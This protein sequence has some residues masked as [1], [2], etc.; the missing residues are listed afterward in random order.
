MPADDAGN[1]ASNVRSAGIALALVGA[2]SAG[3][4]SSVDRRASGAALA[5]QVGIL[6]GL[7]VSLGW[8][9]PAE[10]RRIQRRTSDSLLAATGGAAVI[11][12][13]LAAGDVAAAL[14]AA[15]ED[16]A[17]A[18]TVALSVRLGGR[19]EPNVSAIP[20]FLV[21]AVSIVD[22]RVHVEVR[23]AATQEIIG[24]V[25]TV[26]SGRP[27]EPEVG[28][29]G[30]RRAAL[31]AIDDALRKTV[32]AFAPRLASSHRAF[33]VA[34]DAAGPQ[35]S[36][37]VRL[38]RL[39]ELYPE[40]SVDDMEAL[41]LSADSLL[42]LDPGPLLALGVMRGDLLRLPRAATKSARA[43]LARALSR[44][45]PLSLEVDRHGEH[46]LLAALAGPAGRDRN[47]R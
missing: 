31:A 36:F 26:S 22:Y 38:S 23:S 9:G 37:T 16:P 41:A 30:E 47:Q 18:L 40:L 46:Y 34:E 45:A 15:G 8:G 29:H 19:R 32:R 14:R 28:P 44:G 17:R 1:V 6:V 39:A 43:V 20:G 35:A 11:A 25:D 42:V 4:F 10:L 27:N 7:P 5:P 12:E 21:G 2:A 24:L 3:C 33:E 13:E